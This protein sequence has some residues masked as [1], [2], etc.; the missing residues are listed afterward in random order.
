MT[1]M[2]SETRDCPERT[3]RRLRKATACQGGRKPRGQRTEVRGQKSEFIDQS[4]RPARAHAHAH[5][6][7]R[8]RDSFGKRPTSNTQRPTPNVRVTVR[9]AFM[10]MFM[11]MFM[12]MLML[13]LVPQLRNGRSSPRLMCDND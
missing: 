13:M 4:N 2:A 7:A 11:F 1:I 12:L 9:P 3:D 5:A 10:F 8:D 6:H